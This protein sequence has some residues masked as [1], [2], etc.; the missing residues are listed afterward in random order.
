MCSGMQRYKDRF[1][2]RDGGRISSLQSCIRTDDLN[3]VGDG[4]HLSYFEMLG[5]FSFG[6]ND[7]QL[8][9]EMWDN[10]LRELKI[11]SSEIHVHPTQSSHNLIWTRL[12][13]N[14]VSNPDCVWSDGNIGGYCCEIYCNGLEIGNLVNTDAVSTDVGFGWERLIQVIQEKTHV[15]GTSLFRQDVNPV[16]ADHLRAIKVF[17]E[18]DIEPGNKGRNYICRKILRRLIQ[19]TGSDFGIELITKERE[20]REERLKFGSRMLRKHGDK[21]DEFWWKT[22]GILPEERCLIT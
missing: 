4:S 22:F 14:V 18:N 15:Q 7:Y 1:I 16:I 10:L 20:I 13:H 21:P 9:V 5:N 11:T 6:N 2:R 12:G 19:L 17:I 3:L 8:S